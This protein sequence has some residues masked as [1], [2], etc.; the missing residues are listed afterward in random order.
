LKAKFKLEFAPRFERRFKALD[1]Q[2]QIRI[3]REAQILAENPHA[4]RRLK[5]QWEGT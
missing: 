3:L 2:N 4:G 1:R 5:G